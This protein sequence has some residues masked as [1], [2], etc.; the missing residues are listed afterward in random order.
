MLLQISKASSLQNLDYCL[1]AH[2]FQASIGFTQ[3]LPH[4]TWVIAANCIQK[5]QQT[6]QL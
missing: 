1:L 2:D 4:G 5:T 3:V 6:L